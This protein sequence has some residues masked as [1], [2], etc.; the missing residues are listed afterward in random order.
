MEIYQNTKLKRMNAYYRIFDSNGDMLVV[1]E[2]GYIVNKHAYMIWR[3]LDEE[4]TLNGLLQDLC[5]YVKNAREEDL[6][7]RV[8][9]TIKLF[10]VRHLLEVNGSAIDQLKY[11]YQNTQDEM[12][13]CNEYKMMPI[14]QVDLVVTSGCNFKCRH[15]FISQESRKK[16]SHI[17]LADWKKIIDKLSSNGLVS[18]VIT[19]GEPLTYVFL[20]DLLDYIDKLGIRIQ[21]LTNGYLLTEEKINRLSKYKN[22]VVQV[23]LDGSRALSNDFQRGKGSYEK[24]AENVSMLVKYQIETIVAMVLNK[25]N[26]KD[27]Y[28]NSMFHEMESMGVNVLAITPSIIKISNALNNSDDFLEA[29]EALEAIRYIKKYTFNYTGKTIINISAPP[30]LAEDCSITRVRKER[31]RCR[32]G[33][34]SFSIRS[35]GDVCVCSD[36]MEIGY[37]EYELGNI[38]NN[39]FCDILVRLNKVKEDKHQNLLKVKGVCSICKELL[40]CGGACRAAAVAQYGD[41]LAPYPLCQE[42]YDKGDFPKEY[43]HSDREYADYTIIRERGQNEEL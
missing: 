37:P 40:Y 1:I 30:A 7:D 43:I 6:I 25:T 11:T 27:I 21:L 10:Y 5:K 41:I 13:L 18:V 33:T 28:D 39:N 32:R 42:L 8:I 4:K 29:D 3:L 34:N 31:S 36:F 2:P 35:N 16:N 12:D 24:I 20:F 26:V 23:S 22:I 19:G 15:C 9:D 17:A 38:L 14:T